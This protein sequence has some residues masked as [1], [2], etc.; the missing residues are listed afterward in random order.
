MNVS[1]LVNNPL[2]NRLFKAFLKIGHRHDKSNAMISL[3]C[4][5]LC[6]TIIENIE[7]YRDHMDDLIELCPSYLWEEKLNDAIE[8][9]ES[10]VIDRLQSVLD[11]LKLE[12]VQSIESHHDFD[13][14]RRELLRKIGKW[15]EWSSWWNRVYFLPLTQSQWPSGRLVNIQRIEFLHFA[16]PE[17]WSSSSLYT[18]AYARHFE[19]VHIYFKKIFPRLF[20]INEVFSCSQFVG[21]SFPLY[22]MHITLVRRTF[23]ALFPNRMNTVRVLRQFRFILFVFFS[24]LSYNVYILILYFLEREFVT[25]LRAPNIYTERERHT[26]TYN[27]YLMSCTHTH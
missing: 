17:N 26:H 12:C 23:Y 8:S 4:Y 1:G 3:E 14:F 15:I 11:E 27:A 22:S 16:R 13:R 5:E 21:K 9:E 19:N 7:R 6:N 2:G 10:E 18:S 20:E 25:S 24:F